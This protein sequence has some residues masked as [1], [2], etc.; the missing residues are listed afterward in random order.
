MNPHAALVFP[1]RHR[2]LTIVCMAQG[3]ADAAR[4]MDIGRRHDD[5]IAVRVATSSGMRP[6]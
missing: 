4:Q 2:E 1:E 5:A 6:Q 3:F